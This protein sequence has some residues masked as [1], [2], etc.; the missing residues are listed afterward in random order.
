MDL[1]REANR[2]LDWLEREWL[3]TNGLPSPTG[4]Q[5]VL[6][7]VWSRSVTVQTDLSYVETQRWRQ[8]NL[9]WRS[10]HLDCPLFPDSSFFL[11][12][13]VGQPSVAT[14][15]IGSLFWQEVCH[16]N[17]TFCVGMKMALGIT[18]KADA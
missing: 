18:A 4:R 14:V 7:E 6:N 2:K 13:H 3:F 12:V 11:K 9:V 17:R 15:N 16:S 1:A 5:R 10:A 8:E